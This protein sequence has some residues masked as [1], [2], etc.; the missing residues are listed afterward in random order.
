MR[1]PVVSRVPGGVYHTY[2]RHIPAAEERTTGHGPVLCRQR[3]DVRYAMYRTHQNPVLE[4]VKKNRGVSVCDSRT[5]TSVRKKIST[6]L[7]PA[8]IS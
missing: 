7:S 6:R 4:I 8:P 5:V 3:D 1:L 2:G